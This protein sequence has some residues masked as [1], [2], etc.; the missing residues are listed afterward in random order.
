MRVN[1]F[2]FVLAA[3][4]LCIVFSARAQ[5]IIVPDMASLAQDTVVKNRLINSLNSFLNQKDGPNKDN[6]YVLKEDLPE[7]SALLDEMK[8]MEQSNRYNINNF[9]KCH[10]TN[11]IKLE[12]GDYLVQF[13]Y[14]GIADSIPVLRA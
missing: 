5:S 6:K 2:R 3:I 13:S 1:P 10:L 9:Y 4:S 8:G 14:L 12:G 7:T 11:V